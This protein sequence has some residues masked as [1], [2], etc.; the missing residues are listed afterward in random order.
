MTATYPFF[1]WR[2]FMNGQ[3]KFWWH[4]MELLLVSIRGCV[5]TSISFVKQ[6]LPLTELFV[7][8]RSFQLQRFHLWNWHSWP[9]DRS[10]KF[11]KVCENCLIY[12]QLPSYFLSDAKM[13]AHS[14]RRNGGIWA[15]GLPV[16]PSSRYSEE[17]EVADFILIEK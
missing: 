2:T 14:C 12:M 4:T 9:A 15:F 13:G 17:E 8:I 1:P 5:L 11:R 16:M 7:I 6:L 3:T 10:F